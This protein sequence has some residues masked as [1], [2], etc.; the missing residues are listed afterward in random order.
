MRIDP[1]K[2]SEVIRKTVEP[3]KT[4]PVELSA[5]SAGQPAGVVQADQ[6]ALSQSAA[7]VQRA[8]QALGGVAEVRQEKVAEAKQKIVDGTLEIDAE[9]IAAQIITGG[10]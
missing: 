5:V 10:I 3:V 7:E 4:E 2:L 9:Q 1:R 6:V 8:Q